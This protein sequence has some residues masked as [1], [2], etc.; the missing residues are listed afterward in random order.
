MTRWKRK[1]SLPVPSFSRSLSS[2]DVNDDACN[3]ECDD[4]EGE[5]EH[6]FQVL[7]ANSTKIS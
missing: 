1:K 5:C 7:M 2:V 4:D 3:D 6:T